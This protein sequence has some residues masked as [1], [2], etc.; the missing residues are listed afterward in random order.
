GIPVA[1]VVDTLDATGFIGLQ[2]HSIGDSALAGKKVYFKNIRI[3][4]EDLQPQDF[5][6]GVYPVNLAPNSLTAY[7]TQSGYKLL[8]DGHSNTGWVGAYIDA[9]PANGWEI[10]DGII[11]VLPADGRESTNGGDIVTTEQFSA[12]DLSIEFKLTEGA[13]S[14]VKYF[15]TLAE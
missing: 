2:V 4:T 9:F 11:T 10:K 6:Q 5:P 7:E 3:Q 1:Y 14:G 15:V 8:F 12:F 13:N